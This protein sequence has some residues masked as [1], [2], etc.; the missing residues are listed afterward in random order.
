MLHPP[1]SNRQ[2][3]RVGFAHGECYPG[4]PTRE[5]S[6]LTERGGKKKKAQCPVG[7]PFNGPDFLSIPET[8]R[9]TR[10]AAGVCSGKHS[11]GSGGK[12]KLAGLEGVT[13][14]WTCS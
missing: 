4:Q 10:T 11:R 7:H 3:R 1:P 9:K 6:S 2:G 12:E 13:S 8:G 5:P 14:A